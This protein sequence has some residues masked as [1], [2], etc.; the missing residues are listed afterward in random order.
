MHLDDVLTELVE[1]CGDRLLRVAYQLTHD[2][3]AAQDLVREALLRVYQS[4]RRRGLAPEDWY[5]YLC[6]AAVAGRRTRQPRQPAHLEAT[7]SP[8]ADRLHG[9]GGPQTNYLTGVAYPGGARSRRHQ[10]RAPARHVLPGVPRSGRGP[11]LPVPGLTRRPRPRCGRQHQSH[12]HRDAGQLVAPAGRHE[13]ETGLKSHRHHQPHDPSA[14]GQ[15]ERHEIPDPVRSGAVEPRIQCVC[16]IVLA[17][18][19]PGFSA[20]GRGQGAGRVCAR[21][22]VAA[23]SPERSAPSI[24]PAQAPAVCSPAKCTRP[25]GAAMRSSSPSATVTVSAE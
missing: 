12:Q 14:A 13:P 22:S 17:Q 25:S 4:V 10:A 9:L 3:A 6:R 19:N 24:K 8:S 11:L 5:A 18:W 21:T 23:R 1:Q 7:Q 15:F 2:A 20:F 16:A